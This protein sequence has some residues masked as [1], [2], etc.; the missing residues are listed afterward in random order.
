MVK[1]TASHS[2][3]WP[4]TN[5][6]VPKKHIGSEQNDTLNGQP[7]THLRFRSITFHIRNLRRASDTMINKS[8]GKKKTE[9][10]RG[11]KWN[12]AVV[13][14]KVEYIEFFVPSPPASDFASNNWYASARSIIFAPLPLCPRPVFSAA[15]RPAYPFHLWA[16]ATAAKHFIKL[17]CNWLSGWDRDG[18]CVCVPELMATHRNHKLNRD[19][20]WSAWSTICVTRLR[21]KVCCA[22]KKF[23]SCVRSFAPFHAPQCGSLCCQCP[24][25]VQCEKFAIKIQVLLHVHFMTPSSSLIQNHL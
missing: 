6:N 14:S 16:M 2:V 11:K 10:H 25:C 20:T 23:I 24:C 19:A 15:I 18:V 7:V 12:I 5:K 22:P 8:G 4:A 17:M 1:W 3:A 9:E 21:P 13:I